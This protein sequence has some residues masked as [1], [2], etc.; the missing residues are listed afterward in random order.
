M[1]SWTLSAGSWI[2]KAAT[3]RRHENGLGEA[4]SRSF[5]HW[6][7]EKLRGQALEVRSG[8]RCGSRLWRE[9]DTG[10][11]WS[12]RRRPSHVAEE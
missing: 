6:A 12:Y 4:Q 3:T 5:F 2:S 8:A 1:G 10:Y 11:S 7:A 9:K